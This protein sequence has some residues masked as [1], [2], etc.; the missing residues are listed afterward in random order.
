MIKKKVWLV[1][2]CL[3]MVILFLF[4]TNITMA[5]EKLA[6]YTTLDEPLAHAVMAAFEE[7]T[8]IEVEWVRLSGVNV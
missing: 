6:I 1:G 4:S 7:D 8:G 5:K 2:L 3:V